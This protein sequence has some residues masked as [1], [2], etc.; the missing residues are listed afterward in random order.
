MTLPEGDRYSWPDSTY[1]RKP[2][3]FEGMDP[4]PA[5][6]EPITG[7][8]VLAVLADSVTTDHISPAGAIKKDSPAGRWLIIA[9]DQR[10]ICLKQERFARKQIEVTPAQIIRLLPSSRMRS[11]QFLVQTLQWSYRIRVRKEDAFRFAAALDALRPTAQAQA[12]LDSVERPWLPGLSALPVV[13]RLMPGST[14]PA[15]DFATREHV[16][17]VE[18]EVDRLQHDVE[19]LQQQASARSTAVA[20]ERCQRGHNSFA[21]GSQAA[22]H[23]EGVVVPCKGAECLIAA[24]GFDGLVVGGLQAD[25]DFVLRNCCH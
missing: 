18:A 14:G 25:A 21:Q 20:G 23:R 1:V 2:S 10:L 16:A 5:E 19:R 3:F 6:I 15:P 8:R 13:R 7:A 11:Y 9:T 12:Q 22:L 24:H 17:R 4:E